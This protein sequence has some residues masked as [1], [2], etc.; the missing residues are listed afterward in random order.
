[1]IDETKIFEVNPATIIIKDELPRQRKDLGKIEELADSI[2]KFGQLLPV[3]INENNE[4]IAGGRRL[5]A[6][7][8]LARNV[9]VCYSN[10]VDPLTMRELELEENLQ[11]K[12]L[13]PA[14]EALAIKEIVDIKQKIHGAPL[15]GVGGGF[16][17]DDA[18]KIVGKSR[19]MVSEA[20]KLAEIVELFPSL[21]ECKTSTEIK[22]AAKA[23]QR[24]QQQMEALASYEETIKKSKE[25]ILVN[26]AAE[27]YLRG[28]GENSVDLLFTDP[29]YGIDIHEVAMTPGGET[30]GEHST[31]EVKYDD[32][33][34]Y[35][36]NLLT[37]IA[38]ESYRIVKPT[39]HALIFCAP[40]HFWWLSEVMKSA[41]WL[42]APRPVVWIKRET[43]QNNMPERWF[44]A[45][46][47]F[48]LFAR[49]ASSTLALQGK[50]DWIQCDIVPPSTRVHQAEKP[51]LLCKE[52]I[53]RCCLPGQYLLDPCMGSGAIIAAGIQM[54][55][56]CL[57]CEKDTAVYASAVSRM[58]STV[59]NR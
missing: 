7:L 13:T 6:C 39:G 11:R 48:I 15:P 36:K 8:L 33:E 59:E 10:A 50:P 55:L 51:I 27:D 58:F 47:E 26:R 20:L 56:L 29:P 22:S 21:A 24:T 40:S 30:G 2:Q 49:K 38:N 57:G 54:K 14:E 53:S 17:L 12:S 18:A 25:F 41:G 43:G 23:L 35:A 52:L 19:S 44:S 16:T 45:T 3:I 37:V 34:D 46:Y 42:V 31:T 32:S 5:A 28:L 9:R 4:L 1:M